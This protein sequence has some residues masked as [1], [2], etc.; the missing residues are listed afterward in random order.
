MGFLFRCWFIAITVFWFA[1]FVVFGCCLVLTWLVSCLFVCFVLG[2]YLIVDFAGWVTL[3]GVRWFVYFRVVVCLIV[4]FRCCF[5][6]SWFCCVACID[7]FYCLRGFGYVDDVSVVW[8]GCG[9][10]GLGRYVL[11]LDCVCL[12]IWCVCLICLICFV[13]LIWMFVGVYG[14]ALN[15]FVECWLLVWFGGCLFDGL[16]WYCLIVRCFCWCLL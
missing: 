5:W 7:L 10:L 14:L 12:V 1:G 6:F 3:F 4:L 9:A 15:A 16:C 8:V 13:C 11:V 2:C